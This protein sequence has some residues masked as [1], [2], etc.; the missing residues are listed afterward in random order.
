MS[1]KKQWQ[2]MTIEEKNI[3]LYRKQVDI[4]DK[5]LVRKAVS[6]DDYDRIICELNNRM[7]NRNDE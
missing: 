4:L 6:Q 5:F 7:L 1:E 3:E 2:S